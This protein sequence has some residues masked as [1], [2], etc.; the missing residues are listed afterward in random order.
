MN[1]IKYSGK[2]QLIFSIGENTFNNI[3]TW[4]ID[5]SKHKLSIIV[6]DGNNL[7]DIHK[8]TNDD[9]SFSPDYLYLT[10]C[11]S[12]KIS[13]FKC[14]VETI[15]LKNNEIEFTY[16]FMFVGTHVSEVF[17]NE[18]KL[19]KSLKY[20]IEST[21]IPIT[22]FISY[23]QTQFEFN[24]NT[25]V[26]NIEQN[27][28]VNVDIEVIALT[29]NMCFNEIISILY[30]VLDILFLCLGFYPYPIREQVT[31][32]DGNDVILFHRD[33]N[34]FEKSR[35]T[36]HWNRILVSPQNM[37]PLDKFINAFYQIFCKD[38]IPIEVL[39]NAIYTTDLFS[40]L[41]LSLVLQCIEG[42]MTEWHD[43]VKFDEDIKKSVINEV[44][45]Y[46]KQN[47]L[48]LTDGFLAQITESV[49]NLLGSINK[50][51]FSERINAAFEVNDFTALIID[52]EKHHKLY[53]IFL[54]KSKSVRNQFAHMN[55]KKNV[56]HDEQLNIALEKYI[57][58]F[59]VLILSDLGIV[60]DKN[61]LKQIIVDIDKY[62]DQ[63]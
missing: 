11:N 5:V 32:F 14:F 12:E 28:F 4:E 35:N 57:L 30:I 55:I 54:K 2:E 27:G 21:P 6:N 39:T 48:C 46:I 29:H 60:I 63:K 31:L 34:I 51:S 41:Q 33:K 52:Y 56:F 13:L 17:K 59:R 3:C 38:N 18:N 37:A 9:R 49:K 36:S 47:K 42:Y 23:G 44:C 58:L 43:D 24:C 22:P 20:T 8:W 10:S 50:Q 53:D 15:I 1:T 7:F 16:D 45:E 40:D 62:Y 26:L 61:N 25:I 19:C